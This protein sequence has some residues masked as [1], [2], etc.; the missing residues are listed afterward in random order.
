MAIT[1]TL[2]ATF[3][4]VWMP[5]YCTLPSFDAHLAIFIDGKSAGDLV[6]MLFDGKLHAELAAIFFV[7]FREENHVAVEPRSGALQGDQHGEIG[8]RHAF[9]VN[10]AA[11]VDVIVF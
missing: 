2:T 4:L 6:P 1:S 5:T 9:V 7:A 11:A 3:S 10:R 8:D